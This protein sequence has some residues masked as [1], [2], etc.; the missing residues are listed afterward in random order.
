MVS[1]YLNLFALDS[2]IFVTNYP[3]LL[4]VEQKKKRVPIPEGTGTRRLLVNAN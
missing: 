4:G 1:Y 3:F 2:Q